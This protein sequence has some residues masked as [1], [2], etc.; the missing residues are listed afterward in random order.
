MNI[1][2]TGF[3]GTGKSA[4]GR[5]LAQRAGR[6]FYDTDQIIEKDAGMSVAEIFSRKGE[7]FF[8]QAESEAIKLVAMLDNLVV[9]V[10]GG[11][12]L[13]EENMEELKK[14]GRVVCLTASPEVIWQRVE[15]NRNRPLLN[16]KDSQAEIKKLLAERASLYQ[17]CDFT[18][19]TDNLNLDQIV[20]K[21]IAL[22]PEL[23]P[24]EGK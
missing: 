8:R 20:E 10:G 21:I 5:K 23:K 1:V 6:D 7:Y 16:K 4:V 15:K 12:A 3:M 24:V 2:L 14:N 13:K 19:Q 9:A 18:V 17:R 11:A 22:M